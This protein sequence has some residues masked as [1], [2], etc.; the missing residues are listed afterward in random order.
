M[1]ARS[2]A[3]FLAPIALVTVAFALYTV[4]EDARKAGDSGSSNG[5][6]AQTTPGHTSTKKSSK[7]ASKK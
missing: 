5:S 1:A 4:V 7:K 6:P 3:R 2:P